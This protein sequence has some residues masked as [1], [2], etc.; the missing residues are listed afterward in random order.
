MTHFENLIHRVR[1]LLSGECQITFEIPSNQ[2]AWFSVPIFHL[3][4]KRN[5]SVAE[6]AKTI[7]S[8]LNS[9]SGVQA[10][11]VGGYVNLAPTSSFARQILAELSTSKYQP[12]S[13]TET[14]VIDYS[15][16][17]AAKPMSIGHLR[18]TVIGDALKR[19]YQFLGYQV[20]GVNHLGDWGTQFGKLLVA[21]KRQFGD[22]TPRPELTVKDLLNLY[23]QFHTDAD[24]DRAL[25]DGARAMFFQLEHERRAQGQAS[26]LVA[27]WRQLVDLSKQE[28]QSVY[29]RLGVE[30]SDEAIKG[31]SEYD[32]EV[33]QVRK[34]AQEMGILE[35]SEGAQIIQVGDACPPLIFE[36]TDGSTTYGA[37]DLGALLYRL[38]TYRPAQVL[39]VVGSEQSLHFQQIFE[40]ATSLDLLGVRTNKTILKHVKFGLV[41]LPEGKLSTRQGRVILLEDVLNE[42]VKRA[43]AVIEARVE[44]QPGDERISEAVGIGALKYFDLMHNCRHDI[45]F[46][47]E[48]M[49]SLKGNSAPYLQYSYTRAVQIL[50]KE[51]DIEQEVG[52]VPVELMPYIRTLARF[53]LIIEQVAEQSTPHTLAQYLGE[54]AADFHAF[55]ERFPVLQASASD[56]TVR[57]AYVRATQ[58]IL[59]IGLN[60]LGI[61][62][63]ERM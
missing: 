43:Q 56:K 50:A 37:R 16:P 48:R 30:F 39:Y 38:K 45:L 3:A 58:K 33:K 53:P 26:E 34:Q 17:N 9:L 8:R 7:V 22:L 62:A 46:N 44:G 55:Y 61:E 51:S 14:I 25:A 59:K 12:E 52:V 24:Q 2:S 57:L 32:L 27:L 23:V 54:V 20:I 31:E 5:Q 41:R 18:S 15:S 28:L 21:Y 13:R 29:R 1:S 11:V 10:K 49:L 4:Q 35:T 6:V 47:W 40:A 60:L 63:L 42:A 19:I 36:K